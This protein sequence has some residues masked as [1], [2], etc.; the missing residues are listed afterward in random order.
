MSHSYF[1]KFRKKFCIHTISLL[2]I[3]LCVLSGCHT[4]SFQSLPI[5]CD[6]PTVP[7]TGYT[8]ALVGD[9]PLNAAKI[10]L[11]ESGKSVVTNHEGQ[12]G[13]CVYPG[14]QIT[15]ELTKNSSSPFENYQT[16]QSGTFFVPQ[17]GMTDKNNEITFQVPR[18]QIFKALKAIISMKYK[19]QLL[20]N[21]CVVAATVTAFGKTMIDDPQGEPDAT[22]VLWH[23]NKPVTDFK[24]FY[25]GIIFDKTNPFDTNINRTS[26]DG[27]AVIYNLPASKDLY[28]LSAQKTGKKFTTERFLCRAGAFINLSPPHGPTV[29]KN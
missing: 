27:G 5:K 4:T 12:F 14:S 22:L 24:A 18:Y 2:V 19:M 10:T 20:P 23:Q 15:L 25:F 11:L 13:F 26:E 9:D 28:Y 16:T 6:F 29:E 7:V 17:A 3:I 1:K 8:K 21:T